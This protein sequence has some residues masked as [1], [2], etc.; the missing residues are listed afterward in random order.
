LASTKHLKNHFGIQ[1]G[2]GGVWLNNESKLSNSIALRS[3]IGIE[4]DF[5]LGSPYDGAGFICNPS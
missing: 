3:E 4:H 1:T 5:T 2:P